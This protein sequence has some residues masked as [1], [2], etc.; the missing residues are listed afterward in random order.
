MST[1]LGALDGFGGVIPVHRAHDLDRVVPAMIRQF[2]RSSARLTEPSPSPWPSLLA[3]PRLVGGRHR[4]AKIHFAH[5]NSVQKKL[6]CTQ[7]LFI[8]QQYEHR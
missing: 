2:S 3:M 8:R 1:D 5:R 4:V 6:F 7:L